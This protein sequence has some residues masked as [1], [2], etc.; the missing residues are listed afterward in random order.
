MLRAHKE[1]GRKVKMRRDGGE[2]RVFTHKK[3][4][5]VGCTKDKTA[6]LPI[7]EKMPHRFI[8]KTNGSR[9]GIENVIF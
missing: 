7:K 8:S 3:A 5:I 4:I 6:H 9:W 2:W 1:S